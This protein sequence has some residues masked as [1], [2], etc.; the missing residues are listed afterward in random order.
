LTRPWPGLALGRPWYVGK[1]PISRDVYRNIFVCVDAAH[2]IWFAALVAGLMTVGIVMQLGWTP[3]PIP[4]SK[5]ALRRGKDTRRDTP[6]SV[7][8]PP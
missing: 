1:H 8:G 4:M 7:G 6:R 5:L 3:G 2:L